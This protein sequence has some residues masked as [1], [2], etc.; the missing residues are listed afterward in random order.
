MGWWRTTSVHYMC[1]TTECRGH[2][3]GFRHH[4]YPTSPTK[5]YA[6]K[7]YSVPPYPAHFCPWMYQRFTTYRG[8]LEVKWQRL[9]EL[10]SG[11]HHRRHG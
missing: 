5:L 8:T 1:T 10:P 6:K 11:V 7:L 9:S 2:G 4:S 3:I